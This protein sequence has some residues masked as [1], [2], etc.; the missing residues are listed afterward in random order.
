MALEEAALGS[1]AEVQGRLEG[2]KEWFKLGDRG[3]ISMEWLR[4]VQHAARVPKGQAAHMQPGT[5]A[6]N[7]LKRLPHSDNAPRQNHHYG[8]PRPEL[9]AVASCDVPGRF[10]AN[11]VSVSAY[12]KA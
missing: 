5:R 8:S 7:R 12:L 3:Q 9:I 10:S 6:R 11:A 1:A 2:I 4:E